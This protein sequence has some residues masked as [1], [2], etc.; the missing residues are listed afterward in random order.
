MDTACSYTFSTGCQMLA[1]AFG[2]LVAI[3]LYREGD[4]D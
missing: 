3:V 4:S 1:G 2:F